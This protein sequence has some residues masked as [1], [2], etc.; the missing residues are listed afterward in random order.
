MILNLAGT[1]FSGMEGQ[2]GFNFLQ[3]LFD[4]VRKPLG[5]GGG[6]GVEPGNNAMA[7]QKQCR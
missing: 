4:T 2:S 1:N 3:L 5:G 6:G 7:S